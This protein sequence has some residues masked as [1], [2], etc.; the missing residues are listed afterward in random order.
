M[1]IEMDKLNLLKNLILMMCCDGNIASQEK[2]FLAKAAKQIAFNV[3]DWNALLK[4]TVA[5]KNP[6]YPIEN[7]ERGI[8]TLKSL[9][10]MAKADKVVDEREKKFLM[11]F[12]K[13]IGISNE[14]WRQIRKQ[15]DI[16]GIFDPFKSITERTGAKITALEED[17]EDLD[18]FIEIS[19]ENGIDIQVIK[20]DDFISSDRNDEDI[21]CFHASEDKDKTVHKCTRLLEKCGQ[22]TISVLTRYQGHQVK[23]ML[24]IGL[25]KCIIEP[26]YTNDIEEMLSFSK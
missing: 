23:Y 3:D 14:E 22:R 20:F 17:F 4:E 9:V 8:A 15:S 12:A 24:E 19:N 7:K 6:F 11:R 18:D 10:I 26:V 25:K 21:I 13:S 2:K 1:S 16:E 5:A